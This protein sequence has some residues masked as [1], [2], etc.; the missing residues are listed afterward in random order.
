MARFLVGQIVIHQLFDY[1]GVIYDYDETYQG[2]A[3]WYER[4]A[5][6]RPPRDQPWYRVLVDEAEH[7]TYVAERNLALDP[8][9]APIKHPRLDELFD[10]LDNGGFY[11]LRGDFH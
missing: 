1:R 4:M 9:A 7:E 5:R 8:D 6:S 2:S 10:G 3:A 11:R